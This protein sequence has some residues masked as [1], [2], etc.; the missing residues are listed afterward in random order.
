MRP[1]MQLREIPEYQK[2]VDLMPPIDFREATYFE[3]MIRDGGFLFHVCPSRFVLGSS[4]RV[5]P[6][7]YRE[8]A[9]HNS[10][11]VDAL[12]HSIDSDHL[13]EQYNQ[14]YTSNYFDADIAASMLAL[15]YCDAKEWAGGPCIVDLGTTVFDVRSIVRDVRLAGAWL[16]SCF[17][18][19]DG[20]MV[21][22]DVNAALRGVRR[23]DFVF[24]DMRNTTTM[25]GATTARYFSN[26]IGDLTKDGIYVM[27]VLDNDESLK[28]LYRKQWYA[29]TP[30]DDASV[31][32]TNTEKAN[33]NNCNAEGERLR[34]VK[35]KLKVLDDFMIPAPSEAELAVMRDIYH[36]TE[37][38]VDRMI[39]AIILA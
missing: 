10:G 13:R 30:L 34:Y 1:I 12:L 26:L 2:L 23:R 24:F 38:E 32:I 4:D 14:L 17:R 7:C 37:A 11:I 22:A 33:K 16:G 21:G 3:P 28:R 25:Q 27:A 19:G 20:R 35:E 29:M 8:A 18:S 9:Y 6:V 36:T 31:V 15:S 39:R 5:L